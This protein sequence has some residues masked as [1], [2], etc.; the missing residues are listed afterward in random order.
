MSRLLIATILLACSVV[1]GQ[2]TK[3]FVLA[4]NRAGVVELIDPI[5][6]QTVGRMHIDLPPNSV[7]L[8]GVSANADGSMIYVEG[9]IADEPN[10]CCSLYSIDLATL[11]MN[12]AASIARSGLGIKGMGNDRL[13]FSPDGHWVFGVRNFR[14]PALDLYDLIQGNIVRKLTPTGLEGDWIASGDWSADNFYL[15]ALKND[16][17]AARLWMASPDTTDLGAGLAVE[18]FVQPSGCNASSFALE[19]IVGIGND[20]FIYEAFGF[21]LDRRAECPNVIAGGAWEIDP[22]TGHLLRQIAPD[23]HFS[24]LIPD[25]DESVLYGLSNGGPN[26]EYPIKLVRIDASDGQILQTRTLGT[27]HWSISIAPLRLAPTGDVQVIQDSQSKAHE[28]NRID[29]R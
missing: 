2:V 12:Q 18:S 28:S 4:A 3:Q 13:H 7:G 8:N 23:L 9:P 17:S 27:D 22:S 16:G 10:G 20:L 19:Q 26:W 6:L 5:S 14:G 11:Q 1:S 21:K 15:Y 29:P 25:R 24:V